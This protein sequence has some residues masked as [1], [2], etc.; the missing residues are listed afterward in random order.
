VKGLSQLP[1]CWTNLLVGR[2]RL[3]VIGCVITTAWL[4]TIAVAPTP[5]LASTSPITATWSGRID[6][7][8]VYDPSDPAFEETT[9]GYNWQYSIT[10]KPT[11]R[12]GK[13]VG[14]PQLQVDGQIVSVA[15][16]PNE[17]LDC[18]GTL[19][20]RPS[21][22]IT[23]FGPVGIVWNR[24]HWRVDAFAPDNGSWVQSSADP[25][26][27]CGNT[28]NSGS[29][30]PPCGP[31]IQPVKV[32]RPS[33]LPYVKSVSFNGTGSYPNGGVN[34]WVSGSMTLVVSGAGGRSPGA[35][36][37]PRTPARYRAK[38][39]AAVALPTTFERMLY[40]CV[41]TAATIPLYGLGPPGQVAALTVGAVGG[42]LCAAYLKTVNELAQVIK[43]PPSGSYNTIAKVAPVTAPSVDF[44]SCSRWTGSAATFCTQIEPKLAAVLST[45]QRAQ[46]IAAA[47]RTTVARETGALNAHNHAAAARQ[48]RALGGLDR[49]FAAAMTAETAAGA[50]LE[51]LVAPT[52]LQLTLTS[53]QTAA[54][55]NTVVSKLARMG[56]SKAKLASLLG[57]VGVASPNDWLLALAT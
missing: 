11:G 42:P 1:V 9:A 23:Q 15:A 13:V 2:W 27:N 4:S 10:V 3:C 46:A 17:V 44:P 47:M 16:P 48:D 24:T 55:T 30:S 7:T 18:K 40:P 37:A 20:K 5:A 29:P 35:P 6:W 22:P 21:A 41:V 52:G 14:K 57:G 26:S 53:A 34:C 43:D 56:L 36:N 12:G 50:A 33:A 38:A 54:A 25:H 39:L 51:S 19:S 45:A 32:L 31:N 49:R 8:T 28:E